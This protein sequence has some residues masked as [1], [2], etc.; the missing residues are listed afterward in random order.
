MLGKLKNH[1]L[2]FIELF[3]VMKTSIGSPSEPD[4]VDPVFF[5]LYYEIIL[6]EHGWL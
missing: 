1:D 4:D 2:A 5:R 6:I 3:R